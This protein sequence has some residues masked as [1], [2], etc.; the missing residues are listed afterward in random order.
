MGG[1]AVD[2]AQE[3][4]WPGLLRSRQAQLWAANVSQ[5]RGI[6]RGWDVKRLH[7]GLRLPAGSKVYYRAWHKRYESRIYAFE[8]L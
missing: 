6:A 8:A 1:R 5:C 2:E 3:D 4:H 7:S